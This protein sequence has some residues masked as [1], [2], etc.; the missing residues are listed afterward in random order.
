MSNFNLFYLLK[1]IVS[2]A[3]EADN[4]EVSKDYHILRK[5]IDDEEQFIEVRALGEELAMQVIRY[6]CYHSK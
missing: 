3:S 6:L 4:P 5:M 2:C 1:L